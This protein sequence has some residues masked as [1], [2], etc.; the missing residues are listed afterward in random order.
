MKD[1]NYDLIK[2]LQVKLDTVARL[3]RSC[4]KDAEEARC[5]SLPALKQILEDEKKHAEAIAEEIRMRVKANV[6]N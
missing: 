2:L 6:F 4:I 3:E 1:I 5:H